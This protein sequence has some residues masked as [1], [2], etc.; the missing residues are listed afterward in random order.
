MIKPAPLSQSGTEFKNM[1]KCTV[2]SQFHFPALLTS[3]AF[4]DSAAS[5]REFDPTEPPPRKR[6]LGNTAPTTFQLYTGRGKVAG[7][8]SF[9]ALP[10]EIRPSLR[11]R[12]D[13]AKHKF[14][15]ISTPDLQPMPHT[16][17]RLSL[18]RPTVSFVSSPYADTPIATTAPILPKFSFEELSPTC[19]S[20]LYP[21]ALSVSSQLQPAFESAK[22]LTPLVTYSSFTK[23]PAQIWKELSKDASVLQDSNLAHTTASSTNPCSP[24]GRSQLWRRPTIP[25][26]QNSA[27]FSALCSSGRG[28]SPPKLDSD[29]SLKDFFDM[30]HSNQC[31]CSKH[32]SEKPYLPNDIGDASLLSLPGMEANSTSAQPRE[33]GLHPGGDSSRS[34]E[35]NS[36]STP[37][38]TG[39][40][41]GADSEIDS[42][43]SDS[44]FEDWYD[45]DDITCQKVA[46]ED[47]WAFV[48]HGAQDREFQSH[49]PSDSASESSARTYEA[50]VSTS[51][52]LTP[53]LTPNISLD[54]TMRTVASDLNGGDTP[55]SWMMKAVCFSQSQDCAM[56]LRFECIC[57]SASVSAVEWPSLQE[58]VGVRQRG[59]TQGMW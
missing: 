36:T 55:N 43:I 6:K 54:S 59:I 53:P 10:D 28:A 32:T 50:S 57:S 24:V 37:T 58:S 18:L 40:D 33:Q 16:K 45:L 42:Q 52:P 48:S 47:D 26:V 23:S 7:A 56:C 44:E 1:S 38:E 25:K 29:G 31:W 9:G 35:P 13:A 51:L 17:H 30:G 14:M 22:I 4:A 20:S 34:H 12:R 27:L 3:P 5:P 11:V 19:T 46:Y 15:E 41:V 21:A 8:T 2:S 49:S 39:T